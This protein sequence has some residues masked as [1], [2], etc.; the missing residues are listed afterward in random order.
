MKQ[1]TED[2]LKSF[3]EA[4]YK[5]RGIK[6]EGKDLYNAAHDLLE[7]F[8]ALIKYDQEDKAVKNKDKTDK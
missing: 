4:V 3:Q 6:L 8:E 1:L 2:D 7:F 5:D